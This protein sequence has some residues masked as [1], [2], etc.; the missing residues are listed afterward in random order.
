MTSE[1]T[2]ASA[3]ITLHED[4]AAD[5]VWL[6]GEVEDWLLHTDALVLHDL[7]RFLGPAGLTT[8]RAAHVVE[9]LGR[10]SSLI[11]RRRRGGSA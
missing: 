1:L 5:L 8:T 9:Q 6:L 7:D 2:S 10:Y 11:G 3:L 4:E